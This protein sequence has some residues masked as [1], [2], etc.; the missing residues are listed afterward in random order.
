MIEIDGLKH[1]YGDVKAVDDLSLKVKPGEIHGL[2][3]PD[4]AGKTTAMRVLTSLL[5]LQEGRASINNISVEKPSEIRPLIGYM[6]QRFSLYPDLSVAENLDFF[7]HIFDVTK[8]ER[9]EREKRLYEFSTLGPYKDRPAGKLSGGMKQKLALMCALIH[10]PQALILDEPTTGVDPVSREDFWNIL[11]TIKNEN[12]PILVS[13]PYMD[14]ASQCDQVTLM[15]EGRILSN[16]NPDALIDGAEFRILKSSWTNKMYDPEKISS[17]PGFIGVQPFGKCLHWFIDT[18][19][20]IEEA[21][22]AAEKLGLEQIDPDFEKPDMEDVF[23]YQM[24]YSDAG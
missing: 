12:I 10:V 18:N 21:V 24:E 20:R 8:E 14:E 15:N 9:K 19:T 13:T 1:K 22:K 4:G 7:A 17:I 6:P 5:P 3:G 2:L 11:H 23:I 16:G